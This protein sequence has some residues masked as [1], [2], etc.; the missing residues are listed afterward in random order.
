MIGAYIADFAANAPKLVIE[1]DGHLHGGTA[2]Y[3]EARTAYLTAQGYRVVRFT[4]SD[5]M[6]NLEG[7]LRL[8]DGF[9]THPLSQPSPLKGRGL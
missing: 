1:L 2:A 3:D 9:L 4:N 5:V 8:L 6:F 7:V